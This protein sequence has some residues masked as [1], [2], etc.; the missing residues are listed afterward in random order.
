M[1]TNYVPD[2]GRYTHI[3][4]ELKPYSRLSRMLNRQM[5]H[6]AV[7]EIAAILCGQSRTTEVVSMDLH[8]E[9]YILDGL[10]RVLIFW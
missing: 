1:T 5:Q 3:F 8:H 6:V 2:H 7:G 10:E 4:R 9:P